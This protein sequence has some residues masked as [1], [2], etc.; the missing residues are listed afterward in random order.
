VATESLL[1]AKSFFVGCEVIFSHLRL[2]ESDRWSET[3]ALLKVASFTEAFPEVN[4]GQFLWACEMWAQG[5]LSGTFHNFPTWRELMAPVYRRENG[6]ANRSWGFSPSLP[7]YL[8][9]TAQ[10]LLMLPR[11]KKSM[12]PRSDS[13]QERWLT[14]V[15]MQEWT[16]ADGRPMESKPDNTPLLGGSH[17]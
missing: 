3:V 9:P 16:A 13:S 12:L 1:T 7:K 5:A 15:T 14:P 8:Q 4:D 6:L 11:E 2:K 10:Q 17:E